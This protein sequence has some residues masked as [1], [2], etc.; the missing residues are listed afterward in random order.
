MAKRI[1]FGLLIVLVVIQ[2]IRPERNT[3]PGRQATALGL[4][5][6]VPEQ[7]GTILQKACNDCHSNNTRY[8]WYS[9]IQPVGWWLQHHVNEGK[10]K[11]NFDAFTSYS[12]RRQAKKMDETAELVEKGAMPLDSYTW[13]HKDAKLTATERSALVAWA[14]EVERLAADSTRPNTD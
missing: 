7:V 9:N 4:Q 3:H 14:H 11:L 12:R 6:P 13:I 2:F 8:P 1:F 5:Y 10:G